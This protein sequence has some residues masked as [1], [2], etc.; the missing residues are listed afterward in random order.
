MEGVNKLQGEGKQKLF[1]G[2]HVPWKAWAL[3]QEKLSEK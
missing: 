3:E 2:M 1:V